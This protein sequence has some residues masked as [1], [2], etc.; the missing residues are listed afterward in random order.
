VAVADDGI[1]FAGC[2][3]GLFSGG[4]VMGKPGEWL[5]ELLG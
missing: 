5:F 2:A 3:K 4:V 1:C